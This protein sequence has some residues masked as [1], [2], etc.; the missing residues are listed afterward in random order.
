MS[1]KMDL[2]MKEYGDLLKAEGVNLD[3]IQAKDM[4][5]ELDLNDP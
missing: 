1:K 2:L 5:E 3:E 4:P